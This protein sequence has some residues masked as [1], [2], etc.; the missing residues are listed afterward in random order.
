MRLPVVLIALSSVLAACSSDVATD[1]S[2]STNYSAFKTYQFAPSQPHTA[3]TLDAGRVEQA[4]ASELYQKGLSEASAGADLTVRHSIIEQRDYRSYGTSFGFGYG[5]R[6]WGM[7]YSAPMDFEEY[8][9]GKLVVELID[10][11]NN[12]IVWRAISRKKLT[13]SMSTNSRRQFIDGQIHEMFKE[14]PPNQVTASSTS[15]Y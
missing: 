4:I 6:S 3:T 11:A 5:Y 10:N 12:Q 15:S 7:A 9:Y 14:Y 2:Q 13:E 8:R 1:Y